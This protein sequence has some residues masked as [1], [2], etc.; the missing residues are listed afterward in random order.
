MSVAR[1]LIVEDDAIQQSDLTQLV[2]SCGF[3]VA[4]AADGREALAKIGAAPFSAIITDLVMPRMDG[5]ALLKELAARGDRT[6]AIV[7]TGCGGVD[8]AVSVVHDLKA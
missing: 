2:E 8:R 7:L 5:F 4:V 6:P 3:Q 1:V